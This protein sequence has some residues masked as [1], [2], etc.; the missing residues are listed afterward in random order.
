MQIIRSIA[1]MQQV[2]DELRREGKTI[3]FVPTMGYL[4]EGHLSLLRR[5]RE[6]S[7][8]TV[9]SI[10]VN[11]T[12]FAPNEDLDRYPRDFERDEALARAEG[13][14]ILF[15]PSVEE[16]YPQPYRTYVTVEEITRV[17]CGRSRPTHFRGVTTVVSKLFHIVKPHLA[18]FGQ[19]DAQ[20]AIVIKQM[21]RDLNFD[22]E[23]VVGPIV[24]EPDG[25]AL[26]SRNVYLSPEE[27]KQA[28]LLYQSLMK[29]KEHIEN[30]ERDAGQVR[31]AIESVLQ[32]A[33]LARVD[34]IEI[35]DT[36]DLKPLNPLQGEVLIALAVF[37]GRTRLIDNVMVQIPSENFRR[38]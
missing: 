12:Q 20:Q 15:Y 18:V 5:A 16:M 30:G 25:L 24:R 10:F 2:S 9:L 17:L 19:K 6:L 29:A 14:D 4:H 27:R 26:S 33:P 22:V 3:G 37:F 23:I 35:V 32:K 7:D 36:R 21:V 28:P 1:E 11:P 38:E 34:Y 13:C 31:K 8:K